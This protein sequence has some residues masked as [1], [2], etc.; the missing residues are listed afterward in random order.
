[1]THQSRVVTFWKHFYFYT[2]AF[3]LIFVPILFVGNT[4][5]LFEFPKMFFIHGVAAILA[6]K[7]ISDILLKKVEIRQFP[8]AVSFYIVAFLVSTLLSSHLYTSLWGYYSRFTD[9]LFSLIS[10]GIFYIVVKETLSLNELKILKG[11][12]LFSAIPVSLF[13]ISQHFGLF[14]EI[15]WFGEKTARVYSTFGQPNWLA[16][17]LV[18]IVPFVI[19]KFI[20]S[21]KGL[22]WYLQYLIIFMC[23]WFTYSMS[24]FLGFGVVFSLLLIYI[25]KSFGF[26]KNLLKLVFLTIPLI[27]VPILFPGIAFEKLKDAKNDLLGNTSVK[28]FAQTDPISQRAEYSISDPGYIRKHLWLGTW[29]LIVSDPKI[30]L[31]G[32]GPETFPYAFQKFRPIALNYSSEWNYV[33]NKP[34]NYFLETFAE[35]GIIGLISLF[36]LMAYFYTKSSTLN[37]IS[38]TGLFVTSVFGW[39]VA[40]TWL[41]FWIL[42]AEIETTNNV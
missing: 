15:L 13:G 31:V 5:E 35:T 9:S 21:E 27:M 1:M 23:L 41:I 19:Y 38:I 28:V 20:T 26:R 16:Q 42:L 24:G 22:V 8:I 29:D 40:S 11:I 32:T 14:S 6:T 10:F 2:I 7:F 17:Y 39:P 25:V 30:F 36:G 37:K 33:F 18:M 4:N 3:T 34:H 12:M